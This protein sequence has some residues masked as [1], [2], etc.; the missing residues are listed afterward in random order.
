MIKLHHTNLLKTLKKVEA[1]V[2][3]SCKK[4]QNTII[5]NIYNESQE[6]VPI[7]TGALKASCKKT[8]NSVSYSNDYAIYVHEDLN[9]AHKSGT[10]AKFLE[11]P[12][13]KHTTNIIDKFKKGLK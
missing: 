2:K 7:S 9:S 13:S 5:D 11:I 10:S 6:L 1:K 3:H 8:N 12:Y 4:T